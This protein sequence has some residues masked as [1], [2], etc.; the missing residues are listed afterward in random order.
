MSRNSKQPKINMWIF[1][2][3]L[4][5]KK[6]KI[7]IFKLPNG[8]QF[9]STKKCYVFICEQTETFFNNNNLKLTIF[10]FLFCLIHNFDFYCVLKSK[11]YFFFFFFFLSNFLFFISHRWNEK[12]TKNKF[13]SL[14]NMRELSQMCENNIII[15]HAYKK[16]RKKKFKLKF[17]VL[18]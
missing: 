6:H 13:P 9:I 4:F 8:K 11:K 5:V 7:I 1:V 18:I 15:Y 2:T 16:F 3:F 12:Q 14:I 17:G 10:L